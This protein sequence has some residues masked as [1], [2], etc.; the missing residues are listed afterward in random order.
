MDSKNP[1]NRADIIGILKNKDK[2]EKEK[3]TVKPSV[4]NDTLIRKY[5][6]NY[7]KENKI[8]DKNDDPVWNL[9]HLALQF[10]NI[11]QIS[12]LDGMEK[13]VKLQLDNNI[14]N[15]IEKLDKL[16]NLKW[17]DL[18]FNRITNIEGLENLTKLED[19]SLA[20]NH[21]S[22][23]QNLENLTE[24][25]VFSFGNNLVRYHED[26]VKY[27]RTLKNKL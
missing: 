19:L 3:A 2:M 16:V 17:L 13:L 5:I 4:I 15:K 11:L 20:D 12:N 14:I 1:I 21:I 23:I 27:F 22:L 10:K 25:N 18:S 6:I 9:T 24:L 26:T 7:N 8:F